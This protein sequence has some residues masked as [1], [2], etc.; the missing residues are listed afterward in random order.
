[1]THWLRPKRGYCWCYSRMKW[2]GGVKWYGMNWNKWTNGSSSP[3][4][5]ATH[6][7]K[8]YM[9][10]FKGRVSSFLYFIRFLGN[11]YSRLPQMLTIFWKS[12]EHKTYWKVRT[13]RSKSKHSTQGHPLIMQETS[14]QSRFNARYW[15]LG[16]GALGRPGG[17][18]WGGRRE[19]GSGWGTHVCLWRIHFDIWQN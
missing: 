8:V 6:Q 2:I 16:A 5:L 9:C 3:V 7:G 12:G 14:C 13:H 11:L 18:V 4:S 10:V 19:E 1:M 15:M 17:M